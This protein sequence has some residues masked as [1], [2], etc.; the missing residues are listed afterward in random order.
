M[1]FVAPASLLTAAV[2]LALGAGL[3]GR[4]SGRAGT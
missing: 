4:Q 1:S 2:V 3:I